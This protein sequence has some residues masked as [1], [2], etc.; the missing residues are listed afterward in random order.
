MDEVNGMRLEG[1]SSCNKITTPLN[2]FVLILVCKSYGL[3]LI[4]ET[5]YSISTHYNRS[6]FPLMS[7]SYIV[8]C[9]DHGVK[10]FHNLLCDWPFNIGV[11]HL[12]HHVTVFNI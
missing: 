2:D 6:N 9:E 10:A 8:G 1:R 7:I 11:S 12:C 5:A 4:D 3:L